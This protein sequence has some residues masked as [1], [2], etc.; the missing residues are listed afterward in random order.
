MPGRARPGA[1][2]ATVRSPNGGRH[3]L[4]VATA[5]DGPYGQDAAPGG[6]NVGRPDPGTRSE[7]P[8]PARSIAARGAREIAAPRRPRF[9]RACDL[10]VHSGRTPV[11]VV[12]GVPSGAAPIPAGARSRSAVRSHARFAADEDAC[13]LTRHDRRAALPEV[14]PRPPDPLPRSPCSIVPLLV[15]ADRGARDRARPGQRRR[16][17]RRQGPAEGPRAQDQEPARARRQASTTR[18]TGSRAGSPRRSPSSTASPRT[19]ASRAGASPASRRTSTRSAT[20]YEGLVAS[21]ARPGPQLQRI[22]R[23]ETD[24]RERA[25]RAQ[26]GADGPDP[27]GLR[28]GADVHA[29][30]VPVG[31][32]VHRHARRHEHP[33]GRRRAGPRPRPAD[34]AGPRDA[35]RPPPDGRGDPRRDRPAPPGDRG[36][37]AEAG[38]ADGGAAQAAGAPQGAREGGQGGPGPGEGGLRQ[39]RRGRG[40]AAQA[41]AAAAAAR[42][43][44]QRRIDK[45]IARQVQH[46][47][48]PSEYNGTLALADG[49]DDQRQLRLQHVRVVRTGQRLRPLP[50]RHRHRG[51]LRDAGP[52]VGRRHASCTSAG[53]TRTVPTRPSS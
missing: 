32:L 7:R 37:E 1:N 13:S 49:R 24:K 52:G 5:R 45:L 16:A 27:P 21:L 46:G 19:S 41:I 36:P 40:E 44:L 17:R 43:K 25:A 48:I 15:G 23:Q 14:P 30:D 53:T 51:A 47:N 50:Q 26:G 18:R 42:K 2:R 10:L 38:P 9:R 22:E 4:A 20:A 29:R 31:R 35:A 8:R 33:A 28:G 3:R 12:S 11:Q 6:A 34:R 39:A